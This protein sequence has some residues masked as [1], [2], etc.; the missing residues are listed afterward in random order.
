MMTHED[1]E[2]IVGA[3]HRIAEACSGVTAG[4]NCLGAQVFITGAMIAISRWGRR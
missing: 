1:A 4:L 3:L 2:A